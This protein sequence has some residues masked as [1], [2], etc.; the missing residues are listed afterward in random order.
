M[1]IVMAVVTSPWRRVVF[2][3]C[4]WTWIPAILLFSFGLWLYAQSGKHFSAKQL[5]GLP[6]IREEPQ[7]QRLVTTGIRRRVR[8]PVYL[9]HLCEM[10]AWSLGTGL[11]VCYAL[12]GFALLTGA[13]MIRMEEAELE[14]RFG[15]AFRN[16]KATVPAVLTRIF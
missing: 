3:G 12:T 6:E 2:Y 8:H 16:Y 7:E 9:A 13:L 10:C 14:L 4:S 11:V 5:G 1:W 15:T